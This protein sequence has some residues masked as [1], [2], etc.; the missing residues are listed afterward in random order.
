MGSGRRRR[1]RDECRSAGTG[2][3]EADRLDARVGNQ[4]GAELRPVAEEQGEG[5]CGQTRS[6][7]GVRDGA[8][9]EL[10]GAGVGVVA[11]DHDGASGGKRRRGVAAGDGERQGE[12]AGAEDGDGAQRDR[13]LANVGSWQRGSIGESGVDAGDVPA[14]LPE[15]ACEEAQLPSGTADF[16]GDAGLR[17]SAFGDGAIDD[18]VLDGLDIGGDRFEELGAPLGG[19]S[20]VLGEGRCSGGAGGVDVGRVPVV[21]GGFEVPAG[22]GIEGTDLFPGTP[23]LF[24]GYEHLSRQL[25]VGHRG[26]HGVLGLGWSSWAVV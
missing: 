2:S 23:N 14:S 21:V 8:A 19:R 24:T 18:G 25:S 10:G 26:S 9:D 16:A 3:G 13:A 5:A 11:L 15:N 22:G 20:A 4:S 17:K 7:D 6:G 1:G 12:V